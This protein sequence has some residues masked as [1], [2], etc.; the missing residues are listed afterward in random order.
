MVAD[1]KVHPM[2]DPH[3]IGASLAPF[4]A[5]SLDK[6]IERAHALGFRAVTFSGN[7]AT[8]RNGAPSMSFLWDEL[9]APARDRVRQVRRAFDRAVIHAPFH[10]VPLVSPNPYIEREAL[11]QVLLSVQAAGELDLEVVTV[12]APLRHPRIPPDEFMQRVV[13][14]MRALGDAAER[15]GTRI[16]VENWRYPST[17]DEH[18]ELLEAI[19]HPAVGATIDLGHIAYW[20]AQEGVTRL[21]DAEA[22]AAYNQRLVALIERV[23]PWIIHAHVHDVL[24]DPLVDHRMVG[25]GI[26][27]YEQ[28]LRAFDRINFDGVLLLELSEPDYEHALQVSRERLLAAI[29]AVRDDRADSWPAHKQTRSE[30]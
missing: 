24:P 11:R 30:A 26:I 10:D 3:S 21:A 25:S 14:V 6:A 1:P 22:L 15:A 20:Y 9:D 5:E 4:A 29:A 17:P 27:D 8:P 16:G 19:D 12:H 18:A 13:L 23:A 28:V 7:P 2:L